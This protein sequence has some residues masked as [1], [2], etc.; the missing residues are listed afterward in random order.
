MKENA[1]RFFVGMRILLSLIGVVL[2]VA[3]LVGLFVRVF[4]WV[5]FG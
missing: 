2:F 1:D 4:I 3:I 5:V